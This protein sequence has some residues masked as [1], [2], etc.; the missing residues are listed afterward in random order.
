MP[1]I[2]K[3]PKIL[4]RSDRPALQGGSFREFSTSKL[5]GLLPVLCSLFLSRCAVTPQKPVLAP[6]PEAPQ[7]RHTESRDIT[8]IYDITDYQGKN[9]G[10][11][12]PRWLSLYL[13]GGAKAVER[14]PEFYNRYIFV[15]ANRGNSSEALNQWARGFSGV[16]D[17]P[18]MIALRAEARMTGDTLYPDDEYGEYFERF[19][20]AI[21]DSIFPGISINSVFWIRRRYYAEDGTV[22]RETFE[23]FVLISMTRSLLQREILGI[24]EK[25]QTSVPPTREQSGAIHNLKNTFF[26]GF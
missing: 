12:I 1:C 4:N 22:S 23:F 9:A 10:E 18:R 8:D 25:I 3:I 15:A 11:E 14:L 6:P 17:V 16:R 7:I 19:I 20:K 26:I 24:M 21:A 13:E 2:P 5:R